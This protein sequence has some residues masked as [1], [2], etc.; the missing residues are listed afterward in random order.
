MFT[1][2]STC[3]KILCMDTIVAVAT[4]LTSGGVSIVRLSGEK[5]V[6]IAKQIVSCK[7]P[8]NFLNEPNKMQLVNVKF[9]GVSDKCLIVY[10]KAPKSFTGEDVVEFH[11]HG[12]TKL[13]LNVV[14][15]L[16]EL[17]AKMAEAGEFSKRAFLNGKISLDEAEG[18][19]DI[20]NAQ[21]DAELEAAS[22]LSSGEF[23]SFVKTSQNVL[24][25]SLANLDVLI[26]Y[27]FDDITLQNTL[28]NTNLNLQNLHKNLTQTL[29]SF[30]QGK[31]IKQGI[32]LALIGATN[33]GKSSLLNAMCKNEVAIVSNIAGTTRDVV[34]ESI[35]YKGVKLNILDTA[36][37]RETNNKIEKLGINKSFKTASDSDIIL[38]L[39]DSTKQKLKN[40]LDFVK[41]LNKEKLILVYNKIDK[42][43]NVKILDGF[44][45]VKISAKNKINIETLLDLILKKAGSEKVTN[46][47][48]VITNER[49]FNLVKKAINHLSEAINL[50]VENET[51]ELISFALQGAY[52]AL[53]EI[54]GEVG[55]DKIIDKIF[56]SFCVGK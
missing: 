45:Y 51:I 12:G 18:I 50:I 46:S 55:A 11:L 1:I 6:L 27:E 38:Y 14:N 56:E 13:T 52:N 35:I 23:Y 3:V 42:M 20:I 5:A 43:N 19:V 7:Q 10:F 16:I 34:K 39:I 37:I 40:E 24:L 26:D 47:S 17:G 49:H 31:L 8:L 21:S 41:N 32:D 9:D 33:A 28:K 22:K 25:E 4:S 15:K 44:D 30:K 53:G 54:T 2:I 29:N 36:G 48:I